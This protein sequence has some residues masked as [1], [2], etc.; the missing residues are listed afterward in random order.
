MLK[1]LNSRAARIVTALLLV[2]AALLYSAIR[3]EVVPPSRPLEG[4]PGTLGSWTLVQTGVI[5]QEVL[6][7]LKADDILNG[8]YCNS[9]SPD[10]PKT[11]RGAANLFVAAFRT[12]RNGKTPHSPKNCLPGSGWV[13]LASDEIAIDVGRPAPISVNRYLI[14]YGSER[15]LVLYWYQS[16]DRVVANEYKA[17]FWVMADAIR[18]NRT[19]TALVRVIV[20]VVNRDEAQAQATATA[21]VKSFYSTLLEYL[22]S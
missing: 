6:D 16:R 7:V 4:M 15:Q 22:P 17:K 11:G 9:A 8:M 10:C 20:P 13:P 1:F 2:Q 14:A 19:D 3:P 12:Q 5:E 18:L 21:F